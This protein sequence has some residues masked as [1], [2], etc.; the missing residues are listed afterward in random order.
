[1]TIAVFIGFG[2]LLMNDVSYNH[3]EKPYTFEVK[4]KFMSSEEASETVLNMA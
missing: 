1:M 2:Y 4:D 3:N